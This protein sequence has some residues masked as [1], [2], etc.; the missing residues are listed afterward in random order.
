MIHSFE[1]TNHLGESVELELM[2]PEKSGFIVQSVD[3]L[4]PSKAN[5]NSS[6]LSGADGS[7]FNSSRVNSRN[8]V[9]N[10]KF[11]PT[12]RIEDTRL[13]SYKYF[14]IKKRIKI[15][16]TADNRICYTYGYIESN[17]VDIFSS[18]VSTQISIICPD[19]YFYDVLQRVVKLSGIYPRF[20][21]PFSNESLTEP[22]LEFSEME[23]TS[24][25]NVEYEGDVSVGI[26]LLIHA[27][28]SAEDITFY[29]EYTL[30]SM[31]IDT[32][33][34]A[35]LLVGGGIKAGDDIIISTVIGKKSALILRDGE[36]TNI[37]NALSRDSDWFQLSKGSN[38]FGFTC[39]DG[40]E[41][42]QISI[43]HDVL[44][45]GV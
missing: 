14:P 23:L 18:W 11:L 1:I 13:K 5:I 7:V 30:E 32:D 26:T 37:L 10:L 19:P 25:V 2:F 29:N 36:Y 20:E 22:L 15:K 33:R 34:L 24:V 27:L 45:E 31:F 4:G 21:F 38:V 39:L 40:E 8:L 12:P 3:G 35:A 6:E 28:G 9:F 42:L 17:D 16:I 43:I 44:Y 41:N